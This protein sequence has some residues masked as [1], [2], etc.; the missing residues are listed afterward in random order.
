MVVKTCY[1]CPKRVVDVVVVVGG[2]AS[3]RVGL[4]PMLVAV[5]AVVVVVV[6]CEEEVVVI[7]LVAVFDSLGFLAL[8]GV[9]VVAAVANH[10]Q[11]LL[12]P[13]LTLVDV[14]VAARDEE[15]EE[16]ALAFRQPCCCCFQ[17]QKWLLLQHL[18]VYQTR[19]VPVPS[20]S[21]LL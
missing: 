11:V 10:G 13:S 7:L 1:Y 9:A 17:F 6:Y 14:V 3:R 21:P 16:G 2:G 15:V 8:K 4:A 20:S 18:H 19:H 12:V 5:V